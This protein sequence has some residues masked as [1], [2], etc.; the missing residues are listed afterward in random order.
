[1]LLCSLRQAC[2]SGTYVYLWRRRRSS[3]PKL[4]SRWRYITECSDIQTEGSTKETVQQGRKYL[5]LA[6]VGSGFAEL[7]AT[8]NAVEASKFAHVAHQV[9]LLLCKC[10]IKGCHNKGCPVLK[11]L[12]E[13]SEEDEIQQPH[14]RDSAEN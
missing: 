1:M 13:E 10:C 14:L 2:Q 7:P 5:N 8:W 9:T 11:N 3:K 12:Q 4:A 6:P